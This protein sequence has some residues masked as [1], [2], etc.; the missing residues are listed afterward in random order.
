MS[1]KIEIDEKGFIKNLNRLGLTP[2]QCFAELLTNS[3]DAKA[4][5]IKIIKNKTDVRIID[6]GLG[7]NMQL[8]R[9]KYKLM[10]QRNRTRDTTGCA[11]IGGT[12]SEFILA[13]DKSIVFSKMENSDEIVV[14]E[15][16]WH[17]AHNEFKLFD[18]INFRLANEEESESFLLERDGNHGTSTVL[19]FIKDDDIKIKEVLDSQF[20][21]SKKKKIS[22]FERFDIIFGMNRCN[23][24][25]EY[26]KDPNTLSLKL[27]N[28]RE[29]LN[30][31]MNFKSKRY[32]IQILKKLGNTDEYIYVADNRVIDV[33]GYKNK[34]NNSYKSKLSKYQSYS[35]TEQVGLLVLHLYNPYQK[36]TLIP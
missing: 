8:L 10:K 7:M 11:G 23:I 32:E 35:E 21:E 20:S 4:K 5:N 1:G 34:G 17:L 30:D 33:H 24:T 27:Y 28:I 12:A 3:M 18:S 31:D 22:P 6:D 16:N 15:V 14:A 2:N 29:Y 13:K 25:Y 36:D 9:D 19:Y 26:W